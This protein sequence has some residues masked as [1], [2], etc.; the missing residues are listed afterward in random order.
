M[1]EL[2]AQRSNGKAKVRAAPATLRSAGTS[3]TR[4]R[5]CRIRYGT[6]AAVT[7]LVACACDGCR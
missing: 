2:P 3:V 4:D 7:N 1:F 5:L 6:E